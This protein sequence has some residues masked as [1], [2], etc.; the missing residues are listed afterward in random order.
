MPVHDWTLA[1]SRYFH[2]FHQRWT[3]ATC[4]ALN[5]VAVG[6]RLPEMP[7]FLDTKTY[8]RV[9]LEETYE[10]TWKFCPDEFKERVMRG[11]GPP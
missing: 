8:I 6:D 5:A 10:A 2:Y 9:P 1:P 3:G 7:V 4:D 11:R